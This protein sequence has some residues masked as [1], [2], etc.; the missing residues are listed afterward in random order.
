MPRWTRPHP[1]FTL[2]Q[3]LGRKLLYDLMSFYTR[4]RLVTDLPLDA[5]NL[6]KRFLCIPPSSRP[7]VYRGPLDDAQIK[8]TTVSGTWYPHGVDI[9]SIATAARDRRLL[10]HFHGGGYVLGSGRPLDSGY[11]GAVL[12]RHVAPLALF[13]EY[14]LSCSAE[15][16]F[17]A[18]LQDAL[19]SYLFLLDQGVHSGDIILSGDS[20]GGHLVI[21]LLRYI[22]E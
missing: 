12:S 3:T 8:P 13:A 1:R 16:R 10:L 19:S 2:H 6:G 11:M 17:P 20:A 9:S 18:A 22:H 7:G 21:S 5:D 15:G 4:I 14:R